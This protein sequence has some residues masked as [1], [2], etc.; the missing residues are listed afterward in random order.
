M[1]TVNYFSHGLIIVLIVSFGVCGQTPETNALSEFED[2]AATLVTLKSDQEREDLL[3]KKKNL[4]TPDL[5]KALIQKGNTQLMAGRYSTAFDIYGLAKTIAEQIGDKEGVAAASLDL[6]TIYYLQANY[7]AALDHYRKARDLFTEVTNTFESAK[8]LSGVALIY[9]EQRRDAEALAT[10]QETLKE[11]TSLGHKEEIANTL[12]SMGA[13]Y[14]GQG[15]YSAAA[16]A[17]KKSG[18]ANNSTEALVR[19]ADSLYM[20]GDYSESLKYYQQ[21]LNRVSNGD[22]GALIASLNGAANS[23]YYQGNYQT[24]LEYYR[25]SANI[26]K[27]QPDKLGLANAIKG[28]ANVH[29][30]RGDFAAALDYY[31]SSLSISEQIKAPVG[32][33][34]GSIGLV[35]ALQGDYFRALEFYDR[36]LRE[37]ESNGNTVEQA[38]V[39]SLIG[40]VQYMQASYEPALESYR[41]ALKLREQMADKSGQG[42]VLAGIGSTLLRQKNYSESLD[43]FQRALELFN[44]VGEKESV[45]D[46]LTRVSE[47]FLAQADY[48]KALSAA[49]SAASIAR[50]VDN[51]NLLWYA[52]MLSGKSHHKLE[53]YPQAYQALTDAVSMVESLRSRAPVGAVSDHNLSLAHLTLIDHLLSQHRPGEA[54]DYAERAKV[55]TQFDLLRNSNATTHKGL[56]DAERLQEQQLAGDVAS[57]ELQ[58]NREMQL[59]TSTEARRSNLRDR[60]RRAQQVYSEF[61]QQLFTAH[62]QLK[63]NRGEL[64]PLKLD[65][66]RSLLTDTSTAILEYVITDTNTYLFVLTA[67]NDVSR[68]RRTRRSGTIQLKVYPLEIKNDELLSRVRR[69]EQQLSVRA[70]D[71]ENSAQEL[72]DLLIKPADDQIVL[73]TKLVIVPDGILWRLPFEALQPAEDHYVVDQMQVSYAPSLTVL[74]EMRKRGRVQNQT[75]VAMGNPAL[76]QEFRNRTVLAYGDTK[77]EASLQQEEEIKRVGSIYGGV[78]R[79]LLVGAEANENEFRKEVAN[80]D[81]LHLAAPALLDETSPFS[82]FVGLAPVNQD[83]G[84]VQARELLELQTTAQIVVVSGA[85]RHGQIYGAAAPALSWAW[86]VAGSS[87]T[88]L[89]RWQ[90]EPTAQL[91]LLTHFYSEIKPERRRATSTTKALQ[92]SIKTLRRAREFQHPHFWANFAMIGD[93]R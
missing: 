6:G 26:Q 1:R 70:D 39:L 8:A 43:T 78:K 17:F 10:L 40:N 83:D 53:H 37:F 68:G 9:K 25:R 41:R 77:I 48:P 60:L 35:R 12:N 91:R 31:F 51:T 79:R 45:A 69:F 88:M 58:L 80:A 24:A 42:G 21:S 93:S 29:R 11:F 2:L 30:S 4:M 38:R 36:A 76:S 20:Q 61:R 85:R 19:L 89:S 55:Q 47:A 49:E 34:L 16:E 66:V 87:T 15:N 59:R 27:T 63:I 3:S 82:S 50:Q 74:R 57:F 62:P 18:E 65:E 46:V 14:Y 64:P 7:P 72:Y 54:F 67:E 32:S 84:F 71:F 22:I 33:I 86:F 73:K 13:I 81:I 28:I 23:A 52:R 44:S 56:S 5:R 92:Q 90:V 75:L